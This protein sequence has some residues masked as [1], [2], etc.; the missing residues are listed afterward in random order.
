[1]KKLMFLL[2]FITLSASL[3]AQQ[4]IGLSSILQPHS[5]KINNDTTATFKI[6][7]DKAKSVRLY[8]DWLP[9][10]S[11]VE[12]KQPP[13]DNLVKY[14]IGKLQVKRAIA[15][16]TR[17]IVDDAWSYTTDKL[18]SDLYSYYFIIDGVKVID[19]NN[20]YTMRDVSSLFSIFLIEGGRGDYYKVQKVPHGTISQCWY[21]SP[22]LAMYRRMIVY[23]P[24][25]YE[26]SQHEYP[27]L[28]LLHGLG[29]DE[30]S[31]I[32]T[33]RLAQIMDN[34]IAQEKIVPM[35]VV[36]P[37]GH[38]DHEAAPGYS[39][40]GFIKPSLIST[41]I[42]TENMEISFNSVIAH[43]EN[44]FRVKKDKA[45]RA[46]A[47]LSLGGL[48][49]LYITANNPELFDYIGLF[50][51]ASSKTKPPIDA[52]YQFLDLKLRNQKREGYKLYWIA[53]GKDDS[54]HSA[55]VQYRERLEKI[56]M[57]YV[58]VESDGGHT[59]TNW[60]AYLL[61]YV[62]LLFIFD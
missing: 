30:D 23:T 61:D 19:P 51:P 47:G 10:D 54:L 39:S 13:I 37:N 31:W 29:G 46:I 50:S 5:P 2:A 27:T 44:N 55:L 32:T 43:V 8:G 7:A 58:Y 60:R 14:A 36:M 12:L 35:V 9:K 42:I 45:N 16:V 34:L 18:P 28:Y 33:G 40:S 3:P 11:T 22:K 21:H 20:V 1:M 53:M 57:D 38:T 56:G 15:D 52:T 62:Q 59:W 4:N 26:Q 6:I 25:G 41:D 24:P 17:T 49:T 48:H